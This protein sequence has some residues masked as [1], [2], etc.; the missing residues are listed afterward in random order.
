MTYIE[1]LKYVKENDSA[2]FAVNLKKKELVTIIYDSDPDRY[3]DIIIYYSEETSLDCGAEEDYTPEEFAEEYKDCL[4]EYDFIPCNK[5][6]IGLH[7]F[8]FETIL[9]DM[10]DYKLSE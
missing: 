10:N 9:E 5:D 7:G 1:S 6:I 3:S 2:A 4:N 8:T